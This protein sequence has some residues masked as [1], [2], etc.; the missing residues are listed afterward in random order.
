MIPSSTAVVRV[1][2]ALVCASALQACTP[3]DQKIEK[4]LARAEELIEVY[5]AHNAGL[6]DGL[7]PCSG[8]LD[9]LE[10]LHAEGRRLGVVTAKRRATLE[11]A[12]AAGAPTIGAW[13]WIG[14]PGACIVL[15][16]LAFTMCGNAL[17][18]ILNPRLRQR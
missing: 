17:E 5:S 6:H 7:E 12:F 10:S 2:A 18:E 13:W 11:L 9:A 4:H 3:A 16:V 8:V 14:F 15:V 1:V